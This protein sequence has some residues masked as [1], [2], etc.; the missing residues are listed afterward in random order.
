[1]ERFFVR[2]KAVLVLNKLAALR[3]LFSFRVTSARI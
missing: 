2:M 1:M 3:G